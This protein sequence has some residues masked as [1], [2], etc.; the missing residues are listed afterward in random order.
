MTFDSIGRAVLGPMTK[1]SGYQRNSRITKK[2]QKRLRNN[3]A[4]AAPIDAPIKKASEIVRI[5]SEQGRVKF[6]SASLL[7]CYRGP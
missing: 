2:I 1:L 6:L 5:T 7:S 4:L 3:K